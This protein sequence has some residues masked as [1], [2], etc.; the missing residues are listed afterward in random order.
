MSQIVTLQKVGNSRVL[1]VLSGL[2][3]KIGT[4]GSIIF[5]PISHRNI[6]DKPDWRDY[7]YHKD[8]LEDPQQN[9][10]H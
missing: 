4:D 10:D 1:T 7:D 5:Q 2:S 8:L 6:F 3:V 9:Y